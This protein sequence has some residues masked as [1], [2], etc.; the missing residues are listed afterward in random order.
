MHEILQPAL[1]QALT[2]LYGLQGT[3]HPLPGEYDY[4]FK[5]STEHDRHFLI[6]VIGAQTNLSA[7]DMQNNLLHHL[8]A[9][10][11]VQTPVLIHNLSGE[12]MSDFL[13][14]HNSF[15][16][17]VL[18]WTEGKILAQA[19]PLTA[20]TWQSLGKRLGQLSTAL[21]GF[22]HPKAHH[23]IKWDLAQVEWIVPHFD[24]IKS[25]QNR[26]LI[27][28]F[29]DLLQEKKGIISGIRKSMI[30]ND[31]NDYNI[32]VESSGEAYE[33]IGFVDYGDAVF[34]HTI[35]DLA[36]AIAYAAM[37][38]EK[39]LAVACEIIGAYHDIFPLTDDEI[40]CLYVLVAAR[41]MI[42]LV[43]STMNAEAYP[44]NAYLLVSQQPAWKLLKKWQQ[45]HPR[46]ATY[47]FR[48]ACQILPVPQSA[49]WND[50][51]EQIQVSH[52][53]IP[54]QLA[55]LDLSVASPLLGNW[56]QY[57]SIDQFSKRLDRHCEDIGV[58]C[59]YGGYGEMRSVYSSQHYGDLLEERRSV[60]LGLDIWL[61]EGTVIP[62]P[63]S[64]TI[65]A[66]Q[67][68]AGP[69]NYGATIICEHVVNEIRFWIL[70]GHL[71]LDD[72]DR[73]SIG[74]QF[75]EH[76]N[77]GHIGNPDEN[78]GWAPHVHIQ[79]LLDRLD[80]TG[81]FP[82]VCVPSERDIWLHLCPDPTP[83]FLPH[84]ADTKKTISIADITKRRHQS[85]GANLS[86]SYQKPL[87]IVR[88]KQQ[89]LID[90]EGQY[91]LDSVNN[92]AHVG[93][94]H[95]AVVEAANR[96]NALLN[97]NSRY[98]HENIIVYAE[99]LL[100][101]FPPELDTVYFVN[102]GSEANELA[103]RIARTISN[104]QHMI[105][106]QHGY[107]G[108]T[109]GCIDVSSYKFDGNGGR[110]RPE[111]TILVDMP[112]PFRGKHIGPESG[113]AYALDVRTQLDQIDQEKIAG[114]IHESILSCGGQVVPPAGYLKELYKIVHE[115]GGIRIA[116]E[117]QTGFGR[118]GTT[119][120]AFE[121]HHVI[122]D[123]VTLG[124]PIG[125]GYP[126]G[127]VV[128]KNEIAQAFH[129]GMEF[130]STFGGN[131]VACAVG[132]AV[133]DVLEQEELQ[134]NARQVG[135][136]LKQEWAQLAKEFPLIADVRGHGLFL[137]LEFQTGK[138]A[139]AKQQANY[140]TNRM[141]EHHILSSWDGP[142]KNVIKLKP[143]MCFTMANAAQFVD[144]MRNV[145]QEDFMKAND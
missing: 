133:L 97:T 79:I 2:E 37:D 13:A 124:K 88:G 26:V 53:L 29:F 27:Q 108:N 98:L 35:N 87:H 95:P 9:D 141:R 34:S 118:V 6:K 104:R 125:N 39:P 17:R 77:I 33:V 106:V 5:L 50:F 126:L 15:T 65:A 1:S 132:L 116:D 94:E 119:H 21:R 142:D 111:H 12:W 121:L 40:E 56:Q 112:D 89:Y 90:I 99:R 42:S 105:A 20:K 127:A 45:I 49:N 73:W 84:A 92:V 134:D 102:S 83:L 22:D 10:H 66:L 91:F 14:D 80:L 138:G 113:S 81:D 135:D 143:P 43:V 64:G 117:V 145:L 58:D 70:Y 25:E 24:L 144:Q 62:S 30:Y 63:L 55:P 140:F 4:N 61:P 85:I 82:G 115:F 107:H 38:R 74:D 46:F 69:Q 68:N 8:A 71:S 51:L 16:V 19:N 96:Q 109:S 47:A 100:S 120:W 110:G 67:Y 123:I 93:H 86:I 114:F 54:L 18:S 32:I 101:L 130:F 122:P 44:D 36:I 48:S 72:L 78:G 59:G 103:L 28:Y 129:N 23:W 76:D 131:P 139:P 136:W 41:L 52:S 60:H 11:T 7:V 137:G 31:A 3:L 128:M 75:G 57:K